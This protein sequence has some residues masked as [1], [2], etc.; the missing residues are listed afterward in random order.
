MWIFTFRSLLIQSHESCTNYFWTKKMTFDPTVKKYHIY[1]LVSR[2]SPIFVIDS[3][4]IRSSSKKGVSPWS[5][6]KSLTIIEWQ[7]EGR[8]ILG[9][10]DQ[11]NVDGT[12]NVMLPLVISVVILT[13]QR[14]D[15]LQWQKLV[16]TNVPQNLFDIRIA[17]EICEV[18]WRRESFGI[19]R[20][21]DSSM[22]LRLSRCI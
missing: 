5:S 22:L 15:P 8:H 11:E 20:L 2:S 6:L 4:G 7:E 13:I 19:Q 12:P 3:V 14:R 9:F 17:H 10:Q 21:L 18:V 16:Q 1:S